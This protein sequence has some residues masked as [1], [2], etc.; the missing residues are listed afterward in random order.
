MR[1]KPKPKPARARAEKLRLAD[2]VG[3]KASR[4]RMPSEVFGVLWL[5]LPVRVPPPVEMTAGH[6]GAVADA[7][8]EGALGSVDEL[9]ELAGR[10]ND[11]RSRRD[12]DR[13]LRRA[14]LPAA[15]EAEIDLGR[16]RVAMVG[17]DLA[18]FP[19]G[20]RGVAVRDL[21]ENLFNVALRVPLLLMLQ[22]KNVHPQISR[23]SKEP[24]LYER[25]F[26]RLF[27]DKVTTEW[28]FHPD[29]RALALPEED[30]I[31]PLE[32]RWSYH[33]AHRGDKEKTDQ[34]DWDRGADVASEAEAEAAQERR[35]R[36]E[37]EE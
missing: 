37:S 21:A 1:K 34:D 35:R 29:G 5:L 31:T 26:V 2:F 27:D 16:V 8:E 20:D 28:I 33:S 4:G 32:E 15:R 10:V 7:E 19:A 23:K 12:V 24:E 6:V 14:H 17:A 11:K 36:G 13:L 9:V 25:Q 22:T 18:R 30:W 3:T